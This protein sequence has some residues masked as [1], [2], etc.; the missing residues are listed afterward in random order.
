M[1]NIDKI[2]LDF[3]FS[4]VLFILGLVLIAAYTIYSYKYTVPLVSNRFKTLL[5]SLRTIAL[6][7]ILFVIFEP[8]LNVAYKK[9]I[10]P[11]N[12]FF[13]DNSKSIQ[14]DDKTD[15]KGTVSQFLEKLS[16]SPLK[17]TSELYSFGTNLKRVSVDSLGG[18]F[19][20]SEATTNFSKIFNKIKSDENNIASIVVVSDGV[21]TDGSNPIYQAEKLS[22]P[23]YTFGIGDTTKKDNLEIK[24]VLFNEYV[25]ASNPTTINAAIAS[26]GFKNRAV[27][28]T[29]Y[30]DNV[31][32]VQQNVTLGNE[33]ISSFNIPY[34]PRSAGEK[35]LTLTIS[36]LKGEY[37]YADN[38]KVFYINVLNNKLNT[39]ILA[40]SP[41]ADLSFVRNTLLS[42][43]NLKVNTLTQVSSG[44]FLENVNQS[45]LI[46]SANIMFLVG[47]PSQ[48]TPDYLLNR[49]IHEIRD[50]NKPFFIVLSSGTDY[51]KLKA[52]QAELPFTIGRISPGFTDAQP[53]VTN[54]ELD[55]PLL[56]NNSANNA[57]AWNNLPP[58]PKPNTE[59]YTKPESNLIAKTKINNIP[60]N[61]P[62]II[63]RKLGNKRSLAVLAK[64]IWRWKLQTAEKRFDVFDRLLLGSVKWLN[65]REDQKQVTIK[66]TKKEFSLGEPVEFTAQVYDE[67][68]NPVDGAEINVN[69]NLG[70][71]KY[72]V[73]MNSLSGGLYEGTLVTSAPGDYSFSGSAAFKGRTLGR[74]GGKFSVGDVEIEMINPGMDKDFLTV[75]SKQTGGKFYYGKN[76]DQF[77]NMLQE[78]NK[79]QSKEKMMQSEITLW[80]NEWMLVLIV[81]LFAVEWFLRKRSGML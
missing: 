21:I 20:F 12:L 81:L 3:S 49:V 41:S 14:I 33:A 65:T 13:I 19:S 4:P 40:G 46:D 7:L 72:I 26:T 11:V 32:Q 62:L 30:E 10:Q 42:D 54:E 44:K 56:Q 48:Q 18:R 68:F 23:V 28:L 63:S 69:V 1:F 80:S 2:H 29:L 34:T 31:K 76:F 15:R 5:I 47:F 55:N 24:K 8:V 71:S 67:S 17:K 75:L 57:S 74:D 52:L 61:A 43:E 50:K 22:I 6:L 9:T 38:K 60:L 27:T 59:L 58:V 51:N 53:N 79:K 64:D 70:N 16:K 35:K 78:N 77:F 36:E 66:T 37:T 25:Y 73:N 39:L 45:R